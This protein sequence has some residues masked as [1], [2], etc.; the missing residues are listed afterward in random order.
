MSKLAIFKG[1]SS[2]ECN[3]KDGRLFTKINGFANIC[4]KSE[5]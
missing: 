3:A 2:G 5:Y 1:Y 4:G